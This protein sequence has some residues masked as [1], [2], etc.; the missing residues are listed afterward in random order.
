MAF[1]RAFSATEGFCKTLNKALDRSSD[2]L[3]VSIESSSARLGQVE[4]MLKVVSTKRNQVVELLHNR[5]LAPDDLGLLSKL[6]ND[7][8]EINRILKDD[9]WGDDASYIEHDRIM[10]AIERATANME[11]SKPTRPAFTATL[12]ARTRKLKW[13]T[14]PLSRDVRDPVTS[15]AL[16]AAERLNR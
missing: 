4:S 15:F 13:G 14:R 6:R 11:T 16:G 10:I 7:L 9:Q 5:S 1:Q 12:R 2:L 8:S 3:G